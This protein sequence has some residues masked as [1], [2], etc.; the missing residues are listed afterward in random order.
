MPVKNTG[1]QGTGETDRDIFNN[2]GLASAPSLL[3]S[4]AAQQSTTP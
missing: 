4:E 3:D 1:K 2:T